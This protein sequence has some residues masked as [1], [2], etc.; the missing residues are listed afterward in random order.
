[1]NF[2]QVLEKL[3]NERQGASGLLIILGIWLLAMVLGNIVAGFIMIGLG[4]LSLDEATRL[5]DVIITK[6]NGWLAITLGQG[7][8][9]VVTFIVAAWFYWNVLEKK[10]F[11]EFNFKKLPNWSIFLLAIIIQLVFLPFNGWLQGVNE[12]IGLPASMAGFESVLKGMEESAKQLTDFLTDVDGIGQFL[13]AFIVIAVIAGIGE[14]LI[15]RALIQRKLYKSFKNHHVAI[16][17]AAVIFSA[18]H[19]QFYGFFPR[20]MLGA[21][22]GYFYYFTGNIWV[23]IV[24]HIFNNGLALTMLFLVKRGIVSPEIEKLDMVPIPMVLVSL[25][26]TVW[27]IWFLDKRVKMES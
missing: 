23:P 9:S 15:F 12:N 7:F 2:N 20:V 13:L 3:Q 25:G 16:W 6:P 14:E 17:V 27:G 4:D 24:A 21:L 11:A 18:I 22:F 8:A 10:T 5:M 26:L 19:F 1:M